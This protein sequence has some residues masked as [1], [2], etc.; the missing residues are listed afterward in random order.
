[1]SE[2]MKSITYED[3]YVYLKEKKISDTLGKLKQ[4]GYADEDDYGTIPLPED[5]SFTP[6]PSDGEVY[7][8]TDCGDNFVAFLRGHPIFVDKMEI[9]CGRWRDRLTRYRKVSGIYDGTWPEDRFPYEHLKPAI[10][11]YGIDTGIGS[12]SHF[13]TDYSIGLDLGWG[14]LLD[15]IRKYKVVHKSDESKKALYDAEEKVVLAIQE[16][17]QKHIDEISR[18]LDA[19]EDPAIRDSLSKMLK[20]NENLI[21][22]P[23]QSFLEACQYIAWFNTISRMYDRDG[24]GCWLDQILY[25][26]YTEDLKQGILTKDE[27]VFILANLLL[28][29][30]HYYQISGC[31]DDGNDLTNELSYLI[32]EAAHNLN[33]SANIT[34]RVHDNI[35]PS[36]FHKAVGYVFTDKRGWPRFAGHNGLMNYAKN[37]GVDAK[38]ANQ[39]IAVGCGWCAVPGLEFSMQDCVKINCAKV[40]EVAYTQMMMKAQSMP[41]NDFYAPSLERLLDN[42][43]AHLK[44]AVDVVAQA[45]LFHLEHIHEVFPELVM[46]LQMKNTLEQGLNISQCAE[47][48]TMCVDGVALGIVADSFA[49]IEQRVVREK[50]ITWNELFGAIRSNFREHER[51]RQ[52]LQSSEK[53]CQ[54]S[55]GLGDAWAQKI[56]KLFA[57]TIKEQPMPEGKSL[58][59][60]WFSWSK[61]IFFGKQV[62]ATPNGRQAYEPI[63]HGANPSPGFRTDGAPT[64]LAVGIANIQPGYGNTA[65]LQIEFDPRITVEQGGIERVAQLIRSHFDLGGTLINI[66]ILDKET[67]M[68]AHKDPSLHPDLVVRVTGFTSYFCVLSPEFRQLVVDRFIDH[69]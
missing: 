65:P 60:G 56:S 61:T 18:L 17:I 58:V 16:W 7:G 52:M 67:L 9:L 1:M 24:A 54:G 50:L 22:K 29:D 26:Y 45:I 63:T 59:P 4:N 64:A 40:F 12:D 35:D 30:P 33:I 37:E 68:Q 39:R 13:C 43:H 2:N 62:G 49:A 44:R 46:N 8:A 38:I 69:M 5:Y 15:K 51:M 41:D 42:F 57:Q 19:E 36:F 66:N 20:S 21:E 3:R 25:P 47:L 14:G 6:N 53:Y 10:D 55:N 27:A 48:Y 34:I 31:D 11:L 23:P 32:L 28:I